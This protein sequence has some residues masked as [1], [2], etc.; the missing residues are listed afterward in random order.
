VTG[1]GKSYFG[2]N[3]SNSL[4]LLQVRRANLSVQ[5]AEQ[6]QQFIIRGQLRP[7]DRLPPERELSEQLGVSRTVVREAN[8]Q[9]QERGLVK[10]LTGSGTYVSKVEP[11]AISQAISLFMWG[12]GHTFHDLLESRKMFEVEIAGL[13]AERATTED[14]QQLEGALAQMAAALPRVHADSAGLETFVQADWFFH[15]ILAKASKNSLLPLLLTPI[16]DLLLQFSRQASSLQGASENAIH[17]HNALLQAVRSR[18]SARCRA[19]MRD[20]LMDAEKILDQMADDKVG[21]PKT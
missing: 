13:A 19:V 10:V 5:A 7:G 15:Q 4:D 12:H 20:H 17:F 16:T 18:D 1:N 14:I 6:I 9:L 3:E 2:A 8:K 11:A 21:F